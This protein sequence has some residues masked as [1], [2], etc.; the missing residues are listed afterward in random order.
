[1]KV[2]EL[3]KSEVKACR[4]SDSLNIAAR[5]MWENDCGCV[6]VVDSDNRVLGILT[7][8]DVCMAAY[9]QGLSLHLLQAESA[10]ASPAVCCTPTDKLDTAEKLMRDVKV[11]R[12][13]VCDREGRLLGILSLSDIARTVEREGVPEN[14]MA[15]VARLLG[16]VSEPR[17]HSL[18]HVT[19]AP[20]E[21]ELEF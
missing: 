11:R 8:R 16:A 9:T 18:A 10:M 21:G 17:S 5:I 20:E 19:F 3:M 7:D 4:P 2:R 6:P 13:P 1:M 12:L 14:R 15:E